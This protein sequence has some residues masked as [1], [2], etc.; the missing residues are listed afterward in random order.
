MK[1]IGVKEMVYMEGA[2]IPSV[3]TPMG[4]G[5]LISTGG[6]GNNGSE[7]D[8]DNNDKSIR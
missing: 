8:N 7:M 2:E 1:V 6:V 3:T 4:V 5:S